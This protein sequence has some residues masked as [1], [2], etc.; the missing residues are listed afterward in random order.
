[1]ALQRGAGE[2]AERARSDAAAKRD[3]R[4]QGCDRAVGAEDQPDER[5]DIQQGRDAR[6][7]R[8]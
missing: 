2:L 3:G 7:H 1:M 4:P 5:G 8:P 6:R